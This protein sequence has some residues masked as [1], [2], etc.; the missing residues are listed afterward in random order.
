MKNHIFD[1]DGT[2]ICSKHRQ[3]LKPNGD[4]DLAHWIENAASSHVVMKDSLLPFARY[5]KALQRDGAFPSI[6][7]SR[8]ISHLEID[9]LLKHG[10]HYDKF[11]HRARGDMR[12]DADYK[13]ARIREHLD[14]TG[15]DA[16]HTTLYDDH[17]EVRAA[18][19]ATRVCL[20][21]LLIGVDSPMHV[22]DGNARLLTSDQLS[23]PPL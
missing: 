5:W 21:V 17:P 9:F 8:T 13:V 4:L 3:R 18:V 12:G 11:I 15:W 2:V 1:L 23:S 19:K 16:S 22:D 7:T 14:A 20:L 6:C 10:L